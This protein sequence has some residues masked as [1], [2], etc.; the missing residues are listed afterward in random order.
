MLI[1][2]PDPFGGAIIIGAET[3]TYHNGTN[4][5]S[6]TPPNIQD[7]SIVA[8]ARVDPNGSR[9]LLGDMSGSDKQYS[10]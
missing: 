6:I 4:Y 1:P 3:I 9:Y 8:H 5:H 7:S 2:V 10:Q